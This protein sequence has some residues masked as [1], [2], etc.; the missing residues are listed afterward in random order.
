LRYASTR[1]RNWRWASGSRQASASNHQCRTVCTRGVRSPWSRLLERRV[2]LPIVP[3][4]YVGISDGRQHRPD[5]RRGAGGRIRQH[6]CRSGVR[7]SHRRTLPRIGVSPSINTTADHQWA[8][9]AG[10]WP[11]E[12]GRPGAPAGAEPGRPGAPVSLEPSRVA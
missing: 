7:R 6:R 8:H 5:G 9:S 12:P 11:A 10:S 4:Q 3:L 1:A 2:Q